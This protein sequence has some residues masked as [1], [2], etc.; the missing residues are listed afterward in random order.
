MSGQ[1]GQFYRI[2]RK[3]L[4]EKLPRSQQVSEVAQAYAKAVRDAKQMDITNQSPE[5]FAQQIEESYP[6]HP[7]I[8]GRYTRFR[9]NPGF[10]QTRALIRLM[11]IVASRLW[12]SGEA[13]RK[14]LIAAHDLGHRAV[15]PDSVQ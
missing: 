15:N 13:E 11:R 4:F 3:R 7:G 6:F 12:T 14:Q 2:I 5:Q 8:K 10:Q 1:H 9:E